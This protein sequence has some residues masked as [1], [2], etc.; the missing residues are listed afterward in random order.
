MSPVFIVGP[1]E[2]WA[3]RDD[4]PPAGVPAVAPAR[5]GFLPLLFSF[6]LGALAF[7]GAMALVLYGLQYAS[8]VAARFVEAVA[9]ATVAVA[10][11]ALLFPTRGF[12]A[13]LLG[14]AGTAPVFLAMVGYA[15]LVRMSSGDDYLRAIPSG[16]VVGFALGAG[17]AGPQWPAAQRRLARRA[18][19]ALVVAMVVV[20]LAVP[21]VCRGLVAHPK[22]A[23][24]PRVDDLV[25]TDV[26]P[27]FAP[28]GWAVSWTS[29]WLSV[30]AAGAGRIEGRNVMLTLHSQSPLASAPDS[31]AG[32]R[33]GHLSVV[34][35]LPRPLGRTDRS[36]EAF[37]ALLLGLGLHPR[38]VASLSPTSMSPRG[39]TW[40][41]NEATPNL[42]GQY[43]GLYYHVTPLATP[44][45][46][47]YPDVPPMLAVECTGTHS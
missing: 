31:L 47:G 28:K 35:D 13:C 4:D 27:R 30:N 19:L 32:L 26:L 39:V 17:L 24:L 33:V 29:D 7:S 36:T 2:A 42:Y 8:P 40:L 12:R 1:L 18:A 25:R 20:M 3:M 23:M 15:V 22:S 9:G 46:P 44:H 14:A 43:N 34:L 5:G 45:R 41:Y 21:G 37:K 6:L 16:M 10:L 38:L 11:P